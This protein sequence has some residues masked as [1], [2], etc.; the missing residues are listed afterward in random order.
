MLQQTRVRSNSKT[1]ID[2]IL[3]NAASPKIVSGSLTLSIS[4]HLVQF[5]IA[6]NI[7]LYPSSLKSYIYEHLTKIWPRK[8]YP[9]LLF[10]WL[11]SGNSIDKSFKKVI[12]RF[13]S[14]LDLHASY[15]K[16]SKCK[17]KFRDKPWITSGI[18]KSIS[19]KITTSQN[20]LNWESP[21]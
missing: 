21:I 18:Q 3:L 13:N 6:P 10:N 16:L 17:L 7:F 5:L 19:V 14:L 9:W 1:L 4:D 20:L 11:G 12:D 2:N 8:L 15:K